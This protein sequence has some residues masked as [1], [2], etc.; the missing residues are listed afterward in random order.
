MHLGI[1]QCLYLAVI[2][3]VN[4]FLWQY[5]CTTD[6]KPG[7]RVVRAEEEN[8]FFI[9][10]ESGCCMKLILLPQNTAE[11]GKKS[12]DE[13]EDAEARAGTWANASSGE[14]R[15]SLQPQRRCSPPSTA[16]Y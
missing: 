13:G 11:K 2:Q 16:R 9:R 10:K 7:I 1:W 15:T 12:L 4:F 3:F 6:W 5:Q 14:G 8:F